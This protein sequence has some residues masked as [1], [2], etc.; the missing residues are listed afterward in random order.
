MQRAIYIVLSVVQYIQYTVTEL[1]HGYAAASSALF[2]VSFECIAEFD[3][4]RGG[5]ETR[6]RACLAPRLP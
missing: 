3:A 6:R 2:P 1:Y 4:T 5:R